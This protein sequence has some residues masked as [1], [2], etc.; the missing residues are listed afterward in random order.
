M[1]ET[2]KTAYRIGLGDIDDSTAERPGYMHRLR[3]S[4]LTHSFSKK[5]VLHDISFQVGEGEVIALLG[6][7]GS[8]KST[9]LRCINL[10]ETPDQGTLSVDEDTLSFPLSAAD[11]RRFPTVA[12]KLRQKIGMVFQQFHLWPHMTVLA[13]LTEAPIRVQRR[14]STDVIDEARS[15]LAQFGLGDHESRYPRQLSGG[16]QQRVAIARALMMKPEFILW[17]EPNSGLDPERSRA[18]AELI[19]AWSAKGITQIVATHDIV[20][21]QDMADKV[22]FL[23]QGQLLEQA[24]V[25]NQQIQPKHA[26][27]QAFLLSPS[28]SKNQSAPIP[29]DTHMEPS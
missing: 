8:G 4:H 22:F 10:L 11:E 18:L 7:S 29:T 9:L 28:T 2:L 16:Q 25:I 15:L 5:R 12:R 17:D 26:R 14:N 24:P 1:T 3:L 21:T 20:F 6:S 13:N 23:E 27:F 19:R